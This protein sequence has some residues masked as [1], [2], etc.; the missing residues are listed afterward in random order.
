[1]RNFLDRLRYYFRDCYGIDKLSTC[2]LI[3]SVILSFISFNRYVELVAFA[4]LVY[5]IFRTI[6]RNK[7][8]RYQ[9]LAAFN[10]FIFKMQQ[11]F[12]SIKA[13]FTQRKD[14]KIL[15]CP[16]CSQKLRLPRNKG[17]V[18]ITCSKCGTKFKAKS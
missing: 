8:K 7:Y 9:E 11:K 13:S 17:K 12:Y 3:L 16:N 15:K 14:Y 5:V 2:I 10:S 18:T 6:S 1:M 4:L